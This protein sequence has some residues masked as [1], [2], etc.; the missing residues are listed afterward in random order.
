MKGSGR[1]NE[2]W[3]I[4][5]QRRGVGTLPPRLRHNT[6]QT[7]RERSRRAINQPHSSVLTTNWIVL[8]G[9]PP[10]GSHPCRA[11]LVGCDLLAKTCPDS[12]CRAYSVPPRLGLSSCPV[13][14]AEARQDRRL[15]TSPRLSTD[16][17]C[18]RV[19]S[20]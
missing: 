20:T 15:G 19:T 9:P 13:P 16:L 18:P 17:D 14:N 8:T 1:K 12:E 10:E 2:G 6:S 5:T 4:G 7:I 3:L 11:S